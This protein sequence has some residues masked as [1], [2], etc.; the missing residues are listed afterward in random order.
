MSQEISIADLRR[1]I[2][3]LTSDPP[4][5]VPGVWCAT[6]KQQLLNWLL[7]RG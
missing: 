5:H 1:A 4:S 7:V 6:L 2:E 3:R